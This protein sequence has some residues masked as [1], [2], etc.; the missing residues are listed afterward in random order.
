MDA[1]ERLRKEGFSGW[2]EERQ[3]RG[4]REDDGIACM[5]A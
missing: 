1:D 2:S 5:S 3:G 4:R